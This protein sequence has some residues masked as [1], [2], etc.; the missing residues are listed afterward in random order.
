MSEAP[1]HVQWVAWDGSTS[2]EFTLRWDSGGWVGEGTVSGP[3]VQY[4][5]RLGPGYD[6]RQFLLFRDLEDPDLW[7]ATDGNGRWGEMN[8][9][10]RDDLRGCSAVALSCSPSS[11]LPI[12]RAHSP[13]P[14]D[15][16]T[17]RVATVDVETLEV[18]PLEHTYTLL[19]PL[20]WLLEIP[21][22]GLRTEFEVDEA[23]VLTSA[24]GWFTRIDPMG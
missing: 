6:L 1:L 13:A 11:T 3:E 14:A 19:D 22:I 4:V 24:P 7:L 9:A 23:G 8:G 5:V 2:E 12:V 18:R 10:E 15:R 20:R 21:D 16:H 17:I